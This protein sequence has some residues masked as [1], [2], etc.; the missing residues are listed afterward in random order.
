MKPACCDFEDDR[1]PVAAPNLTRYG[2]VEGKMNIM[3][4][5]WPQ[6]LGEDGV[7]IPLSRAVIEDRRRDHR[8]VTEVHHRTG[9]T[10]HRPN[11]AIRNCKASL[12]VFCDD[13][14]QVFHAVCQAPLP[15]RFE[16]FAQVSPTFPVQSKPGALRSMA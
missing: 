1:S 14:P 8:L 5:G 16:H 3:P 11:S 9:M 12:L 2:G 7:E 15:S 13:P 10:L 4:A 6:A